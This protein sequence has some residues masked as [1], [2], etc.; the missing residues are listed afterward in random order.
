MLGCATEQ[1]AANEPSEA[2]IRAEYDRFAA[3]VRRTVTEYR[4]RHILV[5]KREEADA[6]L[7]EI[8]AGQPFAQVA[9]R[10]SRDPSSSSKGGDLGWAQPLHFTP[11]FSR[12][13]VGLSPQGLSTEPTQTEFGWHVIA[14]DGTRPAEPPRFEEVRERIAERLSRP[15]GAGQ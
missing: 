8:K 7:A 13:M 11:A 15:K 9:K 6:A 14:V 10:V 1:H 4:V 3:H 2:E 12:A 5:E